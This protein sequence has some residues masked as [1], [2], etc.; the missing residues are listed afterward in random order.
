[1][2]FWNFIVLVDRQQQ[3]DHLLGYTINDVHKIQKHIDY[4]YIYI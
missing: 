3:I 1:M 4:I 2:C